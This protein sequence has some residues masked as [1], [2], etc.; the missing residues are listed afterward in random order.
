MWKG[1]TKVLSNSVNTQHYSRPKGV[2]WGKEKSLPTLGYGWE[3]S[4]SRLK[5]K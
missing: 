4:T 5:W 3:L 2:R 1:D